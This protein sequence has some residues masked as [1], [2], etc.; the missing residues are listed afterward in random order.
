MNLQHERR[1]VSAATTSPWTHKFPDELLGV[2]ADGI[3]EQVQQLH[4]RW[5][6]VGDRVVHDKPPVR[7]L[8]VVGA[9]SIDAELLHVTHDAHAQVEQVH[10]L[11]VPYP[12]ASVAAEARPCDASA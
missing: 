12:I 10:L 8:A 6:G 1:N 5:Q 2:H 3:C 7:A 11:L 9:E 4:E